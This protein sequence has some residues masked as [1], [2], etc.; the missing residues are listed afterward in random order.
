MS[1]AATHGPELDEGADA[2][3]AGDVPDDREGE[4]PAPEPSGGGDGGGPDAGEEGDDG[5]EPPGGLSW[6][7]AATLAAALAFLGF[8]VGM[9]VTRD[10]PPGEGSADVGFYRDMITHHEQALGIASLQVSY[11]EDPVV[12]S[13]ASEVLIFQAQELGVMRQTLVDWGYD[14][15]ERPAEAMGWM[16]MAV[17]SEE[18]PGL[19]DDEQVQAMGDARGAEADELFLELMA[20]HHRG[21]LHM[22]HEAVDE[23]DDS[24]VRQLAEIMERNQSG[25]I[26][27]YR[28]R[29]DQLG[30]DVDIAPAEVPPDDLPT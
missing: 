29:A 2:E 22:A 15:A 30:F 25:E 11:G 27:E 1:R 23:V 14:P 10:R 12:R 20:E 13:F 6:G 5:P 4:G 28:N 19:L 16:G 24:G 26:N 21:G 18:M 3:P 9:V 8:A 17:P 7:R